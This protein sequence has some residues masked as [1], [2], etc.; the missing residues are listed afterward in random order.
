[1]FNAGHFSV[2]RKG[3]LF[4]QSL[5]YRLKYKECSYV[6][7]KMVE[8]EQNNFEHIKSLYLSA[9]DQGIIIRGTVFA[10]LRHCK[11]KCYG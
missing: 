4:K 3:L 11:M 7:K 6:Y 2:S 5:I 10:K 1:M 8:F 9:V